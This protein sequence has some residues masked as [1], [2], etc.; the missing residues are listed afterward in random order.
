MFV[1]LQLAISTHVYFAKN[2]AYVPFN[3]WL[4]FQLVPSVL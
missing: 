2:V 3:Y 1:I 4:S